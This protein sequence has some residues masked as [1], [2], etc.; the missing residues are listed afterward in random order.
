MNMHLSRDLEVSERYS[1]YDFPKYI[2]KII[3]THTPV[4]HLMTKISMLNFFLQCAEN[5][6]ITQWVYC[7]YNSHADSKET[8]VIDVNIKYIPG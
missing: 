6:E 3:A 1:F 2:T 5:L 7:V 4:K 8:F